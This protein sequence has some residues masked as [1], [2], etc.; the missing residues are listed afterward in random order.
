MLQEIEVLEINLM[1]KQG[2]KL[3][4]IAK[5]TG[6]SINTIRKY[7]HEIFVCKYLIF[8]FLLLILYTR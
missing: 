1:Y 6:C 7:A 8:Q 4:Q 5:E 3:K 2:K